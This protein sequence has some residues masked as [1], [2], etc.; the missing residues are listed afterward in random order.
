MFYV[1]SIKVDSLVQGTVENARRTRSYTEYYSEEEM[2]DFRFMTTGEYAGIGA[3]ISYKDGHVIINEPYEGLPAAK[4]GLKAGDIILEVDDKDMRKATVQE[5]S[6]ALRG[7]PRTTVKVK[8]QR[9]GESKPITLK[10]VREK[11]TIHPVTHADIVNG[12]IG[13]FHF[14]SFTEN[15][16]KEVRKTFLDLKNK[17]AESLIIDLRGNGGGILEEAV[18]IVNMFVPKG[19]EIVSTKGKVKQWD[20]VYRTNEQPLDTLIPITVLIDTGSA[21]ASEIVAGSLQDLDRAVI[22]G[23]RSFGKGLVQT[24]RNLPYGGSIKLTTQNTT[25]PA[26]EIQ[27]VDYSHVIPMA[28]WH[29]YPTALHVFLYKNGREVRRWGI[30]PDI[31]IEEDQLGRI[32]II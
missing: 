10:I 5:V 13:Y 31:I 14:A 32:S 8:I 23:N 12:N 3:V 21:S 16:A 20:R 17:G 27:T 2:D 11:I 4:A 7:M 26:E 25:S 22:I 28:V 30:T 29:G 9:P 24:T 6:N 1:D 15:S 19:E 18:S